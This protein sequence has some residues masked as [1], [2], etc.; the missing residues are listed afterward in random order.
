[1]ID[2]KAGV[3]PAI[4]TVGAEAPSGGV[5]MEASATAFNIPKDWL[6]W[7]VKTAMNWGT[8]VFFTV[9]GSV[10][11]MNVESSAGIEVEHSDSERGVLVNPEDVLY[12]I[13]NSSDTVMVVVN[14][15]SV[16]LDG[17]EVRGTEGHVPSTL[18]RKTKIDFTIPRDYFS[19]LIRPIEAA[20]GTHFSP[21]KIKINKELISVETTRSH[22]HVTAS[23]INSYAETEVEGYYDLR[24][25]LP[26]KTMPTRHLNVTFARYGQ[27]P[28]VLFI[29]NDSDVVVLAVA[30]TPI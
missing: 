17:A 7:V 1:M 11:I 14:D 9:D 25:I 13:R 20:Y 26:V 22:V 27:E 23:M 24:W 16:I 2:T 28:P 29:G 6:R 5:G 19:E 4:P 18:P 12:T 8:K 15:D 10:R 3:A 21:M 30:P